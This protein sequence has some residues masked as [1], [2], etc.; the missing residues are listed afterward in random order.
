MES[1]ARIVVLLLAVALLLALSRGGWGGVR[2][3]LHAKFIG[4]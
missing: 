1:I 4:G 2:A 3:W